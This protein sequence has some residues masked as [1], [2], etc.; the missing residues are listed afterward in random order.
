MNRVFDT[1]AQRDSADG[2]PRYDLIPPGALLRVAM[3]YMLG[4]ERYG[5]NNW[6]KGMPGQEVLASAMRHIE[7]FRGGDKSED[8]LAAAVWGLLNLM[9]LQ[10]EGRE[11]PFY[12]ID[13]KTQ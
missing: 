7:A 8:H 5:Y 1:G 6:Y 2:K 11:G 3:H 9:Q 12:F 13:D 10:I 4:G